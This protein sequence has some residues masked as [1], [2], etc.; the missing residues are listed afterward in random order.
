MRGTL[1][2]LGG[3]AIGAFR[4]MAGLQAL[5]EQALADCDVADATHPGGTH[6]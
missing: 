4:S 5:L 1:T 6:N 3:P 2:R